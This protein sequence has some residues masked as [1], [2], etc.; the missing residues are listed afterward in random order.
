M[1]N[2]DFIRYLRFEGALDWLWKPITDLGSEIAYILILSALFLRFPKIG[3]QLG[4]Y[5]GLSVT[6]NTL[7]KLTFNAP[8]P[9]DLD[10]SLTSSAA[11]ETGGSPGLPSG[12]A[13]NAA[14][15]WGYLAITQPFLWL[16]IFL[17]ILILLIAFSRLSLGVHFLEDVLVGLIIGVLLAWIASRVYVPEFSW[18]I[19]LGLVVLFGIICFF[20]PETYSRGLAVMLGFVVSRE[21]SV[22]KLLWQQGL[23]VLGGILLAFTLYFGSSLF[24]PDEIKRSGFGAYVRYFLIVLSVAVIYPLILRKR[25]LP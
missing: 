19:N 22:P 6:I 21:F 3:R 5:F 23:F 18:Q 2:L 20:L 16:R 15:T 13:Q 7:L 10:L 25:V 24:L 8:R 14:L 9:Y 12:H 11:Y 4:I 1:E 17:P